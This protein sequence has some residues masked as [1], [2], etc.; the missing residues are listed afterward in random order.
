MCLLLPGVYQLL[1]GVRVRLVNGPGRRRAL[2]RNHVARVDVLAP[3]ARHKEQVQL[4]HENHVL[5]DGVR[6]RRKALDKDR[7]PLG[8]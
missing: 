5:Q 3:S 2:D 4:T 1:D 8:L 7:G 6:V